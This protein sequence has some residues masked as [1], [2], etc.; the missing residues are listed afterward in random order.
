MRKIFLV[1]WF[2]ALF[3]VILVAQG[4]IDPQKR[5][6]FRNESSFAVSLNSSGFGVNYR[7]GTWKNAKNQLLYDFD[8]AYVKH[9]KE[10]KTIIAYNYVTRRYVYGKENLFWE[11]KGYIGWQKELYRKYDRSGISVRFFYSGGASLGFTKPIY[12]D[13]ISFSGA[14]EITSSEPQKFNPGIHQS[15]INGRSSFFMGFDELKVVPGISAKTGLSFEYSE[16][17]EI[18]HALEAGINITAYPKRIPIMATEDNSWLFFTLTVGYRFGK[19]I[20]V[21]EAASS[22]TRKQKREERKRATEQMQ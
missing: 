20:D 16:R 9:P 15:N 4:E 17:D 13:I 10:V 5:V 18:I 3:Q 7:Y 22:K 19:V 6:L 21:S 8:F 1:I 11:L 12:Y 2:L 14:G